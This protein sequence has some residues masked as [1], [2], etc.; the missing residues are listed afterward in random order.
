MLLPCTQKASGGVHQTPCQGF[1]PGPHW[2]TSV[3]QTHLY[4]TPLTWKSWT[5]PNITDSMNGNRYSRRRL[6]RRRA[7]AAGDV[8]AWTDDD[9]SELAAA[10]RWTDCVVPW[11]SPVH[12]AAPAPPPATPST[13]EFGVPYLPRAPPT[14]SL[15]TSA[16]LWRHRKCVHLSLS[17]DVTEASGQPQ[18][19]RSKHS[20]ASYFE[21]PSTNKTE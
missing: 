5:P 1:A 17:N 11:R 3:P 12:H 9:V 13:V 6:N 14:R 18:P 21:M 16:T 7:A 19:P 15:T 8:A 4:F 2:G 20:K 10:A